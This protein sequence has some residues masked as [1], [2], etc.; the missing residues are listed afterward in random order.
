MTSRNVKDHDLPQKLR[1]G[2]PSE[3]LIEG[4]SDAVLQAWS[5]ALYSL[6]EINAEIVPVSLPHTKLALS[7]YYTIALAE[8]SSNL[9]RYDG[10]RFGTKIQHG[11]SLMD[12][13][14]RVFGTEVQKRILLGS[15]ILQSEYIYCFI[16]IVNTNLTS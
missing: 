1:I 10:L 11:C 15:F 7:C 2:V 4:I 6:E 9:A 3:Y 8:A 14:S 5:N 16:I 12:Y 13:R